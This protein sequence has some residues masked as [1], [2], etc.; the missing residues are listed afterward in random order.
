MPEGHVTHR[1]VR[2]QTAALGLD[3]PIRAR[4]PQGRFREGAALLDG[5]ALESL[6]AHGKHLFYRWEGDL[7]LHVHLGLIGKFQIHRGPAPTP[8][9]AT[10]LV[11]ESSAASVF[12]AGPMVCDVITPGEEQ[13]IRGV[14]GPDPI[15]MPRRGHQFVERLGRKRVPVGA[16]LLDQSVIAG[17]GNVYRAE[18]LFL[19]GIHPA[20]PANEVTADEARSLWKLAVTELRRGVELGDILTVK[21][22]DIGVRSRVGLTREEGVYAYQREDLPCHRCGTPIRLSAAAAR[23]IWHCPSC[24]PH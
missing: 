1:N 4:S 20:R 11:L 13:A 17:I 5:R 3:Q 18:L 7:G 19:A 23:K 12:L 9:P 6:E 8:T 10:R 14:L 2:L 24:Q 16:A 15:S 22:H 21:P